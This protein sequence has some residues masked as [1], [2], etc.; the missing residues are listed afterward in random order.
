MNTQVKPNRSSQ[1]RSAPELKERAVRMVF[2][3]RRETGGKHG[4]VKRVIGRRPVRLRRS[5]GDEPRACSRSGN[6]A[7]G[8]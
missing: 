3:L 2:A 4:S 8:R 7:E 6:G 5:F 1:R